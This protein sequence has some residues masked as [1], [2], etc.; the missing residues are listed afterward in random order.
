M[1]DIRHSLETGV[2]KCKCE[3][4]VI[5]TVILRYGNTTTST[6]PTRHATL[7]CFKLQRECYSYYHFARSK[8]SFLQRVE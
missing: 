2:L 8:F 7:L 3:T 6:V 4:L 1:H 5:V